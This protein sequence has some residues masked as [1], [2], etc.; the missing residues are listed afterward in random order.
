MRKTNV[1]LIITL[2]LVLMTSVAFNQVSTASA[3]EVPPVG[4]V[5]VYVPGQSITIVDQNGIEHEYMLATSLKILPTGDPNSITV[6]KF[7]TIIAPANLDKGKQTAVGITV[8]PKVPDGWLKT[9]PAK[10]TSV[11]TEPVTPKATET[12][13]A[14]ATGTPIGTPDGTLTD[15][16][17]PT[18]TPKGGA[19]VVTTNTL[20]EWLR[21]LLQQLLTSK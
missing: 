16:P 10:E 4:I 15:T 1:L 19:T 6:G 14:T 20:I 7:V 8:H 18:A 12:P 2:A 5:V 9:P 3:Q 21:S 13:T 17:T 11:A